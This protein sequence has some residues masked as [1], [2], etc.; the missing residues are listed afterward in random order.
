VNE[1]VASGLPVIVSDRCGCAPELVQD[2]GFTFDPLD[3][4]ELA[5]LLLRMTLLSEDERSRLA[6]TS[7]RVAENFAPD[8]FG[9]GLERAATMAVNLTQK[10]FG[11]INRALLF[12]AARYAR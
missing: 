4:H 2:N 3:E 5:S 11:V 6:E 12:A 10:R 8:R 1:A 9:E 7:C